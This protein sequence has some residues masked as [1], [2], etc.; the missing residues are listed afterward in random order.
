M[1]D[2]E[3]LARTIYGEARGEPFIG[4]VAV[5][6]VVKNRVGRKGWGNTIADVCLKPLQFSCWNMNDPNRAKILAADLDMP[7]FQRAFGIACLVVCGDDLDDPTG[8]ADHYHT[9]ARP[10]VSVTWPPRWARD[11]TVTAIIGAHRFLKS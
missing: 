10:K 8:G 1:I 5:A 11:M 3:T 6:W 4:Q 7:K 2:I 9:I